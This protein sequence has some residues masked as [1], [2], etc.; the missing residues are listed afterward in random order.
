MDIYD[1]M[2]GLGLFGFIVL[3]LFLVLLPA[4]CTIIVGMWI[5]SLLHITGIIWW[6][7][8]ILFFIIILGIMNLLS[9][10]NRK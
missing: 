7:F 9:N 10:F 5:A 3:I 8:M 2:M 4:A 6:A 1:F